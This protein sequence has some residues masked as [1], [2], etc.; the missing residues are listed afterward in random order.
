MRGVSPVVEICP[1][2]TQ[3]KKGKAGRKQPP[4][5]TTLE[6]AGPEDQTLPAA[7][8]RQPK[9][10]RVPGE[11]DSLPPRPR[12]NA[13]LTRVES[14][15]VEGKAGAPRW[16]RQVRETPPQVSVQAVQPATPLQVPVPVQA[17]Q[18]ETAEKK[19]TPPAGPFAGRAKTNR[20]IFGRLPFE[21]MVMILKFLPDLQSVVN[22]SKVCPFVNEVVEENGGYSG[23]LERIL[24]EVSPCPNHIG[25]ILD[26]PSGHVNAYLL[27]CVL[28]LPVLPRSLHSA[29]YI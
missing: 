19:S 8:K 2:L 9:K 5:V 15:E 24:G 27:T 12:K 10:R 28:P 22:V 25:C 23:V 3:G 13:R 18:Q 20:T 14:P 6:V 21:L 1:P 7:P 11:V 29:V 4:C 16:Q 17:V 26:C